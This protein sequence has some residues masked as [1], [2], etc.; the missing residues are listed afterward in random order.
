[1]ANVRIQDLTA[2]PAVI[3]A[4]IYEM[5]NP[6]GTSTKQTITQLQTFMQGNLAS[7]IARLDTADQTTTGG[8]NVTSLSLTTGN[9]TIDCGAR[10][11]QFITANTAAWTITAPANDGSCM[12]LITMPAASGVVPTFS[13]F[14]VGSNTGD[15]ITNAAN[16]KFTLSIWRIN[17]ISGYRV[18][19]HQ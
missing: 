7:P 2:G 9:I 3:A 16:A 15:T 13:G 4:A 1:M 12:L 14:S 8:S 10:P 17:A 18:A 19:A 5:E 11:L 6:V